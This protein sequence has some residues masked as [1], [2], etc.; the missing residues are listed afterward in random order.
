MST[1]DLSNWTE[2]QLI[3][4][5]VGT[6]IAFLLVAAALLIYIRRTRPH[7]SAGEKAPPEESGM[8]G[9]PNIILR[10]K[11]WTGRL[12][13]QIDKAH[14]RQMR[15][16]TDKGH[17]R[18]VLM[19][20]LDLASFAGISQPA[21]GGDDA[22]QPMAAQATPAKESPPQALAGQR[23][24]PATDEEA[25]RRWLQAVGAAS[26][27]IPPDKPFV[28]EI[29][30][31]LQRRLKEKGVGAEVHLRTDVHG[32]V[33]VE[34]DGTLYETPAEISNMAIREAIRAAVGEWEARH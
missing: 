23:G 17:R 16:I 9:H 34:V 21:A 1:L 3:L 7:P 2:Q 10:R 24:Q 25:P 29:E 31:I 27:T 20:A 6:F 12:E 4:L 13:I 18:A 8:G 26:A 30:T 32:I 5:L 33:R 22:Q 14:Y 28:D 19:A 15:E 11:G